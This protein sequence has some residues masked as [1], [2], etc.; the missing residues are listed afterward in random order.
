MNVNVER[1]ETQ[2]SLSQ[3]AY[4]PLSRNFYF[5]IA[6]SNTAELWVSNNSEPVNKVRRAVVAAPLL[7]IRCVSMP[8]TIDSTTSVRKP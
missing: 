1:V 3:L 4:R 7:T 8:P 5:W 2:R 6:A